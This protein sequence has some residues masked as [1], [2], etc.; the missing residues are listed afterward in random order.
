MLSLVD[1]SIAVSGFQGSPRGAGLPS[2][3]AQ[4]EIL[5]PSAPPWGENPRLHIPSTCAR[6]GGRGPRQ[7][8]GG[9]PWLAGVSSI[10]TFQRRF[11]SQIYA[12]V[13]NE[14]RAGPLLSARKIS[15]RSM[16]LY[17][18]QTVPPHKKS[19]AGLVPAARR[20]NAPCW[21]ATSCSPTDFLRS[22]IGARG[23]NF[24]VRNG[25]RCTSPA[26]VADQHGAFSCQGP[27]PAVPWGPHSATRTTL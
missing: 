25:T 7:G 13:K 3:R 16:S 24:W 8:E 6:G 17:R 4:E 15:L 14:Y 12:F 2:R 26:M 27:A 23:L 9:M 22:T 18:D 21:S 20:E 11:Q 10:A 1:L 19:A 5:L